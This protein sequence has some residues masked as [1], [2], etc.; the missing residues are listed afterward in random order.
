MA[1]RKISRRGFLKGTA[2]TATLAASTQIG[3]DAWRQEAFAE[4]GPQKTGVTVSLSTCNAC[5]NKCGM[6]VYSK[7]GRLWKV[8][9]EKKHPYSKGTLCARGH[10]FATNAYNSTRLTDPMKRMEDGTYAPISWEQAYEEIGTR[11]KAI[12]AEHGPQALAMTTDPRPSGQFYS[13]RFIQAFGSANWY[14]HA[15]ACNLS[16]NAGWE[17]ALKKIPSPDF[18]EAECVM[19]IG[20]SYG[21]GIR[22]SSALTL[23]DN[24]ERGMHVIMVDPRYNSTAHMCNEWVAIRPGT[25]LAFILAMSHVLV[26]EGLYDKDF[27]AQ[28]TTGFDEF[29]QAIKDY[30]P[31]WGEKITSISSD[32]IKQ[33][34]RKMA[35]HAPKSF[36]EQ[37]WR[38]AMGCSYKNS[39]QCG[40]AMVLFNALLGCFGRKGGLYWGSSIKLGELADETL[41]KKLPAP[42]APQYG[43]DEF[44][45]AAKGTGVAGVVP[46]GC[47][48]GDIKAAFYYNSNPVMGYGNADQLSERLRK[49]EL[50]VVID[51]QMSETACIADYVLPDTTYIERAEV[52]EA[53]GGKLPI[54][55]LR[56]QGV[57]K[58]LPNTRPV[59]I[60][61]TELAKACGVGDYFT[62][63]LDDAINAQ[64]APFGPE[65]IA[66]VKKNGLA[67]FP[68]KKYVWPETVVI[69]TDDGKIHFAD[70]LWDKA[71]LGRNIKWIETKYTVDQS[72]D[73]EFRL[74]AGK[75][76]IHSHTMTGSIPHLSQISHDY[77]ME[78][79]WINTQR[80]EKLGIQ[81]GDWIE[82]TS[83]VGKSKVQC[84]VTQRIHPD[85]LWT[86]SHYG[87]RSPYLNKG[88]TYGIGSMD[89]TPFDFEPGVGSCMSQEN[90]VHVAKAEV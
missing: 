78:R 41:F 26:T 46:E 36:I 73:D 23:A 74:I 55:E 28:Y 14:T 58:V 76:A 10:G 11:V 43:S 2:A 40:R 64:L 90:L 27:I 8:K 3:L 57:D 88:Q 1:E 24:I 61:F 37:S 22:P 86:P 51:V 9:G 15:S 16:R 50:I 81:D 84:H 42:V 30:T 33:I 54:C 5:S 71:H 38:A 83:E 25:D 44:P 89:H 80:A 29:A 82:I 56:M 20:R 75:Q 67:E 60:I 87:V 47:A 21:D 17:H 19:F 52:A 39:T 6:H 66:E 85:C 35:K 77:N 63:T 70:D 49:A 13:K 34:A 72:H 68:E 7:N 18:G 12:V 48:R 31:E 69:P 4:E 53:V 59:D 62:F 65:K 45:L 32:R 79:V